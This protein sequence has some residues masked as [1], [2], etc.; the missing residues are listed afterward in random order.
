MKENTF[1]E[2]AT[3]QEIRFQ[4]LHPWK[5]TQQFLV[6]INKRVLA[7]QVIILH[8]Q[9]HTDAIS[10]LQKAPFSKAILL[11]PTLQRELTSICIEHNRLMTI[12]DFNCID[13]I[14]AALKA[15]KIQTL[16]VTPL[17]IQAESADVLVIINHAVTRFPGKVTD[18]VLALST[19]LG[20]ALENARFYDQLKQKTRRLKNWSR[21]V[22]QRIQDGTKRLLEQEFQFHALFE[23]ANDGIVVHNRDGVIF[24]A[25]QVACQM[26]GYS[27]KQLINMKWAQIVP[28]E[29]MASQKTFFERILNKNTDHPLE[30]R[31]LKSNGH[32]FFAEISSR[33]VWFHGQETV[34]SFIRNISL[35][36][37]L[38]ISVKESKNK[39]R[40]LV[41]SSLMGVFNVRGNDIL[42]AN[43]ELERLSGYSKE[44]L[45]EI[46]F[47]N[48]IHP[49]D[50]S[51]VIER[52]R[53][54]EN[55]EEVPEHY[56]VRLNRKNNTHFWCDFRACR[57]LQG[58]QPTILGNIIDI[59]ER[60]NMAR[61]LLET[62]KMESISTLAGGIAHDFNN[63]LGGILGYAS[64]LLSDMTPAHPYYADIETI[65]RTAKR[66]A[67]LTSRLLAFARGGKYQVKTLNLNKLINSILPV[68]RESLEHS[69]ELELFLTEDLWRVKGDSQQ[70]QQAV[71]NICINGLDALNGKGKLAIYTDNVQLNARYAKEKLSL[72]GGDYV[73]VVVR[74]NGS[75]MDQK[76]LMRIF[77]PFFTTKTVGDGAGLGMAMV[78]GVVKNHGG[79]IIVDSE[80]QKGTAITFFLPRQS[81][82]PKPQPPKTKSSRALSYRILLVDDELVIREVGQR[83][84]EKGG[85]EIITAPDGTDAVE[86]YEKQSDRIDLVLLDWMMPKM[87]GKE[88]ARRIKEINPEAII[89]FLSGYSPQDKPELLQ[90]GDQYFIQKPFQTDILVKTVKKILHIPT[91]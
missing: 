19:V 12:T 86:I 84:L 90:M 46:G 65:S 71:L 20:L 75:G 11:Q 18:F 58:G 33:R 35:R 36:K 54:R 78:Y 67:E 85:F 23:G 79:N 62:K 39:Y 2:W 68:M 9:K 10:L 37:Q 14:N 1:I 31:L 55:G 59:N 81:G 60:K 38:E 43:S 25:N 16:I 49:E 17:Q 83:M 69:V 80:L 8:W 32:T 51:W 82:A 66:A 24:E 22:E 44:E 21:D 64:L 42:F 72:D 4:A 27:R 48:L 26:L 50:R 73:R 57:I 34:Q 91:Q 47:S 52:E 63:L 29:N 28:S 76:T 3:N 53:R 74:D 15:E 40:T 45:F 61:E 30:S 70:L 7:E 6:E 87:G 56:E 41:E 89:C 5:R 88:T 13:T 77:E